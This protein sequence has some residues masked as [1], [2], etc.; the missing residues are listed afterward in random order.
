MIVNADLS[1]ALGRLAYYLS[2]RDRSAL[3][4]MIEN[5]EI[6]GLSDLP[7]FALEVLR[8]HMSEITQ[9]LRLDGP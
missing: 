7:P 5:D 3:I 4:A 1:R 2:I 6:R 9:G 8:E